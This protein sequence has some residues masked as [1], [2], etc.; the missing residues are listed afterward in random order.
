[1]PSAVTLPGDDIAAPSAGLGDFLAA[2]HGTEWLLVI[3]LIYAA[4]AAFLLPAVPN[5]GERVTLWNL[6]TILICGLLIHFDR[7]KR[8]LAIGVIRDWLPL[9]VLLLAYQEM[10]WFATPQH[11][12]TLETNWVAWDRLFL[13]GGLKAA[14]EAFGPLLPSVLEIAYSLVYTLGPFCLAVL[15]IYRRR[16]RVDRVLFLLTIGV[17]LC[18]AQFPFWPSEPP[19]VVF[20]GQD[21]PSSDTIFRHFNLWLLGNAGI[22]TSVFP[23][24][25][26]AA[27][28]SAAFG[29]WRTLPE[30]KWVG[31]F[32]FVMALLIATATVYGRY[33][34]FADALAGLSMA[35]AALALTMVRDALRLTAV[36]GANVPEAAREMEHA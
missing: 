31:R 14:I 4:A 25:H 1:M 15:Y 20:P 13:R 3:F 16:D 35:F 29:M 32:L 21:L 6:G 33:H 2:V 27:A 34:Y 26:V 23:S 12:H 36:R 11:S 30:H 5:V 24:A 9:A 18:Y 19:R 22:H 7:G 8:F 17:L 10:G 28:F